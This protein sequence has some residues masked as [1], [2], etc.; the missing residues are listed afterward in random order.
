MLAIRPKWK[1]D[2]APAAEGAV[3]AGAGGKA[4][5]GDARKGAAIDP[6]VGVAV[7]GEALNSV[8][9]RQRLACVP[10]TSGA[11]VAGQR[12]AG[13]QGVIEVTVGVRRE[14]DGRQEVLELEH[15]LGG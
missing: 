11:E 13:G 10:E 7:E 9:I 6:P 15:F 5:A 1:G 14:R 3:G 2:I 8:S 12:Q 4:V